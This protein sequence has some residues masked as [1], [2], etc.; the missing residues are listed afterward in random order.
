M[1]EQGEGTLLSPLFCYRERERE[2]EER[3]LSIYLSG[4]IEG[5]EGHA[6]GFGVA[7]CLRFKPCEMTLFYGL[8]PAIPPYKF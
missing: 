2:R 4:K 1:P 7:N 3:G 6:L 5:K 8:N